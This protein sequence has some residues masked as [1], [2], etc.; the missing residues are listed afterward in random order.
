MSFTFRAAVRENTPVLIGIAG[1]SGG[2]KTYSALR[3]ARGLVGPKGKIAF[4]DTE[5]RR[6]F[7]YAE[8]FQFDHGELSPPFTPE[9]YREAVEA[10]E[11]HVGHM[12]AIVIDSMSHEWAGD[13]GCQEIHDESIEKMLGD[14]KDPRR[15]AQ[16]AERLSALGWRDAKLRHKRMMSRLLQC[17]AHLIFCL[18]AEEKIKFEKV[19]ESR[20]GREYER[21]AIVPIGW[22]PICEKNFMFEMTASFMLSDL[23]RHLPTA[24]K[25]QDQHKPFFPLDKPI[26][27]ECG[28][29]LATWAKG[30]TVVAKSNGAAKASGAP[31]ASP[32]DEEDPFGLPPDHGELGAREPELG[33]LQQGL[34]ADAA[35]DP[36]YDE[37]NRVGSEFVRKLEAATSVKAIDDWLKRNS[38]AID[39]MPVDIGTVIYQT[40]ARRKAALT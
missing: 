3:F 17:R 40:A 6:A 19:K 12:G 5:A 32:Q 34:G 27:E 30:G 39:R 10:A 16:K 24:I 35:P 28:A 13:G 1:P 4:I 25:L 33:S 11:K 29:K 21:T 26:G 31:P 18:R 37:A 23:A 20:D 38:A 8:A 2:G 9:R 22:Q 15:R 36:V 14:E 7:H